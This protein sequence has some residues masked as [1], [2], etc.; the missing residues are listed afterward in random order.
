[1]KHEI[2]IVTRREFVFDKR[3][4][5]IGAFGTET[6]LS[7]ESLKSLKDFW[8]SVLSK[9]F[10]SD[11][12]NEYI[13]K[14]LG[15]KYNS[16]PFELK[17]TEEGNQILKKYFN[18]VEEINQYNR[19]FSSEY[20]GYWEPNLIYLEKLFDVLNSK[21]ELYKAE[22]EYLL[23]ISILNSEIYIY[24]HWLDRQNLGSD[25]RKSFISA[26]RKEIVE[27]HHKIKP[28]IN[29][30]DT[31][32]V[33]WLVHDSDLGV[34][35][36]DGM[37][38]YEGNIINENNSK[39]IEKSDLFDLKSKGV[40]SG[41]KEDNF[42]IFNHSKGINGLY[43]RII[44]TDVNSDFLKDA[45]TLKKHLSYDEKKLKI[46]AKILKEMQ[47]SATLSSEEPLIQEFKDNYN[48]RVKAT[49]SGSEIKNPTSLNI[50]VN[51]LSN[52]K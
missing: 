50:A 18:A 8:I 19:Q 42:W 5:G 21:N 38:Y 16:N 29:P 4:N 2:F 40:N 34:E 7:L 30:K 13:N 9:H 37:I 41:Y 6:K 25:A 35:G 52:A 23:N 39:F 22:L 20:V 11:F 12:V 32:V 27:Y 46:Q 28:E 17:N 33:N 36:A 15:E 1:M 3:G 48:R 47:I 51:E 49:G 14:V 24:H 43:D 44:L 31:I 10:L 45:K 26:L